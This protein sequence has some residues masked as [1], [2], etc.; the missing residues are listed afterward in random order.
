MKRLRLTQVRENAGYTRTV[1]GSKSGVHPSHVGAIENGRQVPA[2][3][4]VTLRKLADAL[5]WPGDPAA[6]LDEVES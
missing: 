2:A 3:G 4:S 5:D 6:L 1:L